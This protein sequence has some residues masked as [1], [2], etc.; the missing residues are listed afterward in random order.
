MED[1]TINSF[2]H[3]R[4]AISFEA[5]TRLWSRDN[6]LIC[7]DFPQD[8]DRNEYLKKY[9]TSINA[10]LNWIEKNRT[11]IE[12]ILIE[13]NYLS[14]AEDWAA[15]ADEAEDEEQECYIM[16]D[17]QKVFIP[18]KE[19]DFRNN[20]YLNSVTMTFEDDPEKPEMYLYLSCDPDYFSYH[21]IEILIDEDQNIEILGLIG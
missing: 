3:K 10:L 12:D 14:L 13:N 7:V 9:I 2:E 20:L 8:E 21:D 1:L 17:G 4:D 19:A 18:I 6:I 5:E 16:E 11:K 15:S